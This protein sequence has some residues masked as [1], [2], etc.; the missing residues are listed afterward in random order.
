VAALRARIEDAFTRDDASDIARVLDQNREGGK[1][2]IAEWEQEI[3]ITSD[4]ARRVELA[5]RITAIVAIY[6]KALGDSGP[7]DRLRRAATPER[8][9]RARME[10][11]QVAFRAGDLE[12]ADASAADGLQALADA[13]AAPDHLAL[14]SSLLSVRGGVAA[15]AQDWDGALT[16]FGRA[17][18]RARE[19]G[20]RESVAAGALNLIDVHT[21]RGTFT[22]ADEYLD[23]A[24]EHVTGTPLED[25]L[26]KVLVERGVGLTTAGDVEPAIA[27]FD[28]AIALRPQW[29][30]PWYQ[31]G[32]ARFLAGDPGGALDDYRECA[33]RKSI[34]FTVQREI[35]CL[36][37]VAAGRL[38]IESYR[39]FC[40]VRDKAGQNPEEAEAA[41]DRIVERHPDFAPVWLTRAEIALARNDIEGAT[42][43]AEGALMRDPDPDTAAASLLL[44]WSL[45]KRTKDAAKVTELEQRL[46]SAYPESPAAQLVRRVAE[47]P[48]RS[49]GLRWTYALD[50]TLQIEEVNPPDR[51]PPPPSSP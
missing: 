29:P 15:R 2:L 42:T 11:A 10:E 24:A 26:G 17:L 44:L 48:R 37:D 50:G 22:E 25:V 30:F 9:A 12:K 14:E 47:S 8:R 13:T 23:V 46:S 40:L 35:R 36:E 45:A 49:F 7:M 28:R 21:R 41:I 51:T 19:S 1:Q 33:A 39:S 27:S 3:A 6:E 38:P 18:E 32:W 31:R 43:A 34:F 5:R 4:A 16:L 20:R